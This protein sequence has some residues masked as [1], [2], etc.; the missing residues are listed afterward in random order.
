MIYP[1]V[2]IIVLNWN[3]LGY[4][5]KCLDSLR[6]ITY[7]NYEVIV[8][9][10]GSDKDE[11][12]IL[13]KMYKDYIKTIRCENNIGFAGGNNLGI[14]E[15]YENK[16]SKYVLLLSNDTKVEPN[17]LGE[18][19]KD[20]ENDSN[21]GIVGPKILNPD[22][23]LQLSCWKYHSY[24]NVFA[25]SFLGVSCFYKYYSIKKN[26]EKK[27]VDVILGACLLFEK[28]VLKK[29]GLLDEKIYLYSE[30]TDICY[31]AK[32][33][34]YKIIYCPNSKIIHYGGQGTKNML[35]S[36]LIINSYR[37][38]IYFFH[39]HYGN[40]KALILEKSLILGVCERILFL[41]LKNFFWKDKKTKQYLLNFKKVL[42]WYRV[43]GKT[44]GLKVKKQRKQFHK[45]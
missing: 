38:K 25:K 3:G 34:G 35:K 2:S 14:R 28:E 6:K 13:K 10:N 27:E 16:K 12:F 19:I 23:S 21:I 37:S 15:V 45:K 18:M 44:I 41:E 1:Q 32:K 4:T 29:V 7:P 8:V 22:Y 39:K 30:E 43:K 11:A 5:I 40:F 31:R 42:E 24:L 26:K 33:Y 36:D 20:A 9:D 17:F